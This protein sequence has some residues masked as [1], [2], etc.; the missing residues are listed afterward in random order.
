MTLSSYILITSAILGISV[1]NLRVMRTKGLS[2]RLYALTVFLVL[3]LVALNI[4]FFTDPSEIWILEVG[5]GFA[6]YVGLVVL[7]FPWIAPEVMEKLNMRGD[8]EEK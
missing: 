3:V 8:R 2:L 5:L 6:L 4:W 7:S 1:I